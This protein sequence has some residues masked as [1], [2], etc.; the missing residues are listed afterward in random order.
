MVNIKTLKH[1]ENLHKV[2]NEIKQFVQNAGCQIS[3]MALS[4]FP[5]ENCNKTIKNKKYSRH[6][7]L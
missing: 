6:S 1:S 2:N 3:L 4:K 7:N 5:Y